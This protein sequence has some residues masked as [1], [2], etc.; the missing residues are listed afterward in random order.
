M[1]LCRIDIAMD[2]AA[3]L[4]RLRH[5]LVKRLLWPARDRRELGGAPEAGELVP[6]L[7]DGEGRP[8]DAEALWAAMRAD[9]PPA[10][11]A[12]ARA[13]DAFQ[14]ALSRALAA[15]GRG[16][17]AGVLAFEAD[18]ERLAALVRSLERTP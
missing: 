7:I 16:D 11:A 3:W 1:T 17:V 2:A 18:V 12:E 9:A 5:D 4:A 10:I 13:L 8:V 6:G 15:A 14:A